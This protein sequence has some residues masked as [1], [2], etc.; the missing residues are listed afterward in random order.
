MGR[1][2]KSWCRLTVRW[3]TPG[4]STSKAPQFPLISEIIRGTKPAPSLVPLQQ[5]QRRPMWSAP[6]LSHYSS[7][8]SC[9]GQQRMKSW[10]GS[11][12]LPPGQAEDCL[13]LHLQG[14]RKSTRSHS[15]FH[16][17]PNGAAL[18]K[19]SSLVAVQPCGQCL[20]VLVLLCRI[21][22]FSHCVFCSQSSSFG[23]DPLPLLS[24][25]LPGTV[26]ICI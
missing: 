19:S 22:C 9:T 25:A 5:P 20:L 3:W 4:S 23:S 2:M 10:W 14:K 1:I 7:A 18:L 26:K 6:S 13:E 24:T 12:S 16:R 8:P 21:Q 15:A 17:L 11:C